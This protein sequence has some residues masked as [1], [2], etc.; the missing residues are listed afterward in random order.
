MIAYYPSKPDLVPD[1]S[2]IIALFCP[3]EL[4]SVFF[5]DKDF[6]A[7]SDPP[8]EKEALLGTKMDALLSKAESKVK[9]PS[10]AEDL[11]VEADAEELAVEALVASDDPKGSQRLKKR[12]R[13]DDGDSKSSQKKKK[14]RSDLKK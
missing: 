7:K 12:Q 6:L 10:R 2:A 4:H 11:T 1:D 5:D 8:S 14:F 9:V 13:E 3:G